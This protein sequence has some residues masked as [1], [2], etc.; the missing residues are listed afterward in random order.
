MDPDPLYPFNQMVESI[1]RLCLSLRDLRREN[2]E[3]YFDLPVEKLYQSLEDALDCF[4][5]SRL[6]EENPE[7]DIIPP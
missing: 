3:K 5:R 7:D 4:Y 1:E 2:P 6:K